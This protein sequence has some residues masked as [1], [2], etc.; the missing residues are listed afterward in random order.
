MVNMAYGWNDGHVSEEED[1]DVQEEIYHSSDATLF[2]IEATPSMLEPFTPS[3]TD[4]PPPSTQTREKLG[5]K[6]KPD[7]TTKLQA[8]LRS[9]YAMMRRKAQSAPRDRIG[10]MI[11][12]TAK[13][14]GVKGGSNA[15]KHCQ[16]VQDLALVTAESLVKFKDLLADIEDDPGLLSQMYEVNRGVNALTEAIQGCTD[17]FRR[18]AS[19]PRINK[20]II[21]ITDNDEP[22]P[23]R[24]KLRN[25]AN[26]RRN[27]MALQDLADMDYKIEPFFF[28]PPNHEFDLE[29]FYGKFI[30]MARED[31]NN[32][33]EDDEL[34]DYSD[35][36]IPWPLVHHDIV[37]T[38]S[39]MVDNLRTKEAM[40]R[41]QFQIPFTL[42]EG[43]TIG[44]KGHALVGVERLRL[45][46]KVDLN[47]SH[48]DA[49]L[50]K[51]F[52]KDA[53][54]GDHLDVKTE[55]RK[56]FEIGKVDVDKGSRSAQIFFT[57]AEIRKVKVRPRRALL[58]PVTD[59]V[60]NP[61]MT[62]QTLGRS[63]SMSLLGFVSRTD[64]LKYE[65]TIKHS[66]FI[67][68]DEDAFTG[69]MR[70]FVALME[71]MIRKGV[72]AYA[73]FLSR[74]SGRPQIVILDAQEEV[75]NQKTGVVER[76]AG[77]NIYQLPFADD[78][79]KHRLDKTPSI[80]KPYVEGEDEPEQPEIALATAIVKKLTRVYDPNSYPNP[81]INFF[82]ETLAATALD[83]E[84][85]DPI[86]KTIPAYGTIRDRAGDKI[87]QLKSLIKE[88]ELDPS[89][90]RTSNKKRAHT[91][92]PV[93]SVEDVQEFADKM[94]RLQ[95]KITVADLKEGLRLMGE[96]T[97]G[98]KQPLWDRAIAALAKKG[99]WAEG[100]GEGDNASE[101]LQKAKKKKRMTIE[102][103]NDDDE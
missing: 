53:I 35:I 87:T 80:K 20:K 45:P 14:E 49:V 79:R 63:P 32:D 48:A 89:L 43:T 5:W 83:D 76:P 98:T 57:E 1:D 75:L 27:A 88:D 17:L 93:G 26:E 82:Q 9:A 102:D 90:V 62:P 40:K 92:E 21:L 19:S 41:V 94:T 70:T 56:Y 29:N 18:N 47:T 42:A 11:F 52:Y 33:D 60:T 85:P 13:T 7:A 97:G 51:I 58:L 4:Q 81:A 91:P 71:S 64:F 101:A 65:E 72:I 30:T 44:I 16:I 73:S 67:R 12:N 3:S 23:P 99:L 8:C 6:D 69:S 74:I 84:L 68:P 54:T 55:I 100:D 96:P 50:H 46:T 36:P 28:S 61:L 24:S 39:E 38:L 78:L 37:Q 95:N 10:I 77:I 2:L 59:K 25:A 86:D 34:A 15:K 103:D 22:Y 66:Y 31:N